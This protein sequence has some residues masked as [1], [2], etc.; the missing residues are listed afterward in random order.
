MDI[1]TYTL[2]QAMERLGLQSAN[3]F[4]RLERE[5]PA[6]FVIMKRTSKTTNSRLGVVYDRATLDRFAERREYFKQEKA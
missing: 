4:F 5:Y 2:K 6:A 3:V 1:E